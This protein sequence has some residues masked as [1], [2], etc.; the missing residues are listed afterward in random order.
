MGRSIK[1]GSRLSLILLLF[2]DDV[3]TFSITCLIEDDGV[4]HV[5]VG[6]REIEL[7]PTSPAGRPICNRWEN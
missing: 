6:M 5:C 4:M 2:D 1:N 3:L 7:E